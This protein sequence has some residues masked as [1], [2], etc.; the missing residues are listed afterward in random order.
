[1]DDFK[2]W[3]CNLNAFPI[4]E[5]IKEEFEHKFI[6]VDVD[7]K[8]STNQISATTERAQEAKTT[9]ERHVKLKTGLTEKTHATHSMGTTKGLMGYDKNIKTN[10]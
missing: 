5:S 8:N 6:L 7:N 10:K 2:G 1:M 9:S 4:I 3:F